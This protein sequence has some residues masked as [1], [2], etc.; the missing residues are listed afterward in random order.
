[1]VYMLILSLIDVLK[2]VRHSQ[3]IFYNQVQ[4]YVVRYANKIYLQ[5]IL[6]INVLTCVP[7]LIMVLILHQITIVFNIVLIAS[8]NI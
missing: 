7:L 6:Q 8:I 3:C 1:M 4:I 2:D 5:I